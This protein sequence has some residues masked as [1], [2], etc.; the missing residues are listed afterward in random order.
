VAGTWALAAQKQILVVKDD[1]SMREMLATA[2]RMTGYQVRTA[3]DGLAGLRMLE[4]YEPDVV[5]LDLGLPIASGF[6]VLR[7]LRAVTKSRFTP[8]IAISGLDE[9]LKLARDSADF[10]A[11]IPKPFE[12]DIL[13][14]AVNRAVKQHPV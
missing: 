4:A 1:D 11:T 12:P 5:V 6:D 9:Q 3:A 13:V 14:R 8:V 2:L 10:I 7:E